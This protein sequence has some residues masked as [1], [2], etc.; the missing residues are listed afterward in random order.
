MTNDKNKNQ[1]SIVKKLVVNDIVS[2][3]NNEKISVIT[4]YDYWSAKICDNT[5]IDIILVGDSG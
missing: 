2:M 5:G 3:K 1:K 4:S